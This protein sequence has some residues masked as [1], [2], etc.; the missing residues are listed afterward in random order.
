MANELPKEVLEDIANK[1]AKRLALGLFG[2]DLTPKQCKIVRKI[3]F[4]EHKRMCVSAMTRYGK[5]QCVAIGVCIYILC[6]ENK[7]IALIGP[8]KEQ[9]DILRGYIVELILKCPYLLEIAEISVEGADR[10]KKEASRSRMTFRNGCEYRVFSAHGDANRLMGFGA[11]FII[12]DE[13]CL[14][15]EEANVKIMRM[16]GD[17]AENSVLID[18][19]NPWSRDNKAYDHWIDP[20]YHKIHIDYKIALEEGRTTELFIEEMRNELTPI[21]FCVLYLSDFPEESEDSLFNYAKI[22]EAVNKDL[23]PMARKTKVMGCDI[24]AMGLDRTVIMKAY[25]DGNAYNV[26]D[27]YSE[28]KSPPGTLVGKIIHLADEFDKEKNILFADEVYIDCIGVGSDVYGGVAKNIK[29]IT[30]TIPAHFGKSATKDKRFK[31][32]KAEM[33]FRLSKIFNAGLISIPENKTLI[34]ELL[35][36]KFEYDDTGKMKIIDPEKS[37]DFADALVYTTWRNESMA[38]TI[39]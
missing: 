18:L 31:N 22:M 24:A 38:Y 8:K 25:Y 10:I 14:I 26:F 6:N 21:E 17:D 30:T 7:K 32:K 37:P 20:K 5:S 13:A 1:D 2:Y 4:A 39:G 3:A 9:A 19:F 11:N 34:R 12:R 23:G 16:L 29:S 15:S 35:S 33:Y 28:A 27:I 36:M